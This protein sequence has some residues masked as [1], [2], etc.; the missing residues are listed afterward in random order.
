MHQPILLIGKVAGDRLADEAADKYA[1]DSDQ[2]AVVLE[3][4]HHVTPI[5]RKEADQARHDYSFT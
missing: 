1:E 3:E 4:L 5:W 2:Q